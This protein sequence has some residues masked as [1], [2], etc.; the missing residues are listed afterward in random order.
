MYCAQCG[1]SNQTGGETCE[2]C[3]APMSAR[4]G[5]ETCPS[6]H[7]LIS[8][9]DRYCQ[10][11]GAPLGAADAAG[12][13]EPGPSFVDD[14]PLQVNPTELP[15]W[16]RDLATSEPPA[17]TVAEQ[18]PTE[19]LPDWLRAARSQSPAQADTEPEVGG[20]QTATPAATPPFSL[21]DEFSLIGDE[22]L[23]EWLRA[24]GD[25]E[26]PAPVS[27][28]ADSGTARQLAAAAVLDVPSV[29]R[30][31]LTAPR[32]IDPDAEA[33]ARPD[34]FP[35]EP[36]PNVVPSTASVTEQ[37][38]LPEPE[39]APMAATAPV[40]TPAADRTRRIRILLL[41]LIILV[42]LLAAYYLVGMP[43]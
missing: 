31:W 12:Q 4:S 15:P 19:N 17:P 22:D 39:P 5:P 25:E 29:S 30:A 3:G 42:V 20:T 36:E 8:T 2:V 9:Y 40:S 11:C 26:P 33:T 7:E 27:A 24:L 23:P 41:V 13:F 1:T 35:L 21:S 43:R 16:L 18:G 6:C 14:E 38:V 34:F 10:S 37:V 28:V 32:A